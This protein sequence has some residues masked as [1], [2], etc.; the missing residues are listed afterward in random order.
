VDAAAAVSEGKVA[1]AGTKISAAGTKI[2]AVDSKASAGVLK[3]SGKVEGKLTGSSEHQDQFHLFTDS[4]ES[5]KEEANEIK[6]A[7]KESKEELKEA[8]KESK[9][10]TWSQEEME[11][12][13]SMAARHAALH[14]ESALKHKKGEKHIESKELKKLNKEIKEKKSK[15]HETTH[16]SIKAA[17]EK[18]VIKGMSPVKVGDDFLEGWQHSS[19]SLNSKIFNKVYSYSFKHNNLGSD[20]MN[21]LEGLTDSPTRNGLNA[22]SAA[23]IEIAKNTLKKIHESD[24]VKEMLGKQGKIPGLTATGFLDDDDFDDNSWTHS[25]SSS[26]STGW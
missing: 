19:S 11:T 9:G 24:R 6:Q 1:A 10:H 12:I 4:S 18:A 5:I 23:G 25:W 26:H 17:V 8:A 3:I 22:S 13:S 15:V 2:A 14:V 21:A 7:A 16:H 20:H